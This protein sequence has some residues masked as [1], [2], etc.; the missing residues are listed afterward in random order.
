MSGDQFFIRGLSAKNDIFT[1]GLRDFGVFTRDSFNY[2]QVEVF[3]GPSASAFGRGAAG[4]GINT[5]SKTPY[6]DA[7]GSALGSRSAM[8]EYARVTGDWNQELGDGVAVRLAG[9]VHQNR[10]HR[11]RPDLF[12]ALGHRALDRLRPR[13]A[14]PRSRSP[15]CTRMK[16]SCRTTASRPP[17][18]TGPSS[19]FR[20]PN[21]ASIRRTITASPATSTTQSSTPSRRV[22][23][24]RSITWL[25][26]TSDT[27]Y[28]Y[29]S[30]LL[31]IHARRPA[32]RLC[33]TNLQDGNPAT[34]PLASVG[35]PGPYEQDTQGVQNISTLSLTAPIGGMRNELL[36][37]SDVSWQDNDR[38]GFA[39]ASRETT[40]DLLNPQLGALPGREPG[41]DQPALHHGQGRLG[42][43]QR[44]PLVQRPVVGHGR[45][46]PGALR[47][48]PDRDDTHCD[49]HLQRR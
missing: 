13:Y 6:A 38:N 22:C 9:M 7:A 3:K 40:K 44:P 33:G 45:P 1:D 11:P 41:S 34:I 17:S 8:A 2:G 28:G 15:T 31:A 43:H 30:A 25:T 48:R 36:I 47:S 29:L 4:G 27:K 37:G 49:R 5:T 20:C 21:S 18:A 14:T 24:T 16:R 23:A 19:A 42:V 10:E 12:G 39:F 26:L 32:T 46:A 35:G